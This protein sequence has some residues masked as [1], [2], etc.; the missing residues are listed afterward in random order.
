MLNIYCSGEECTIRPEG[1]KRGNRSA[2]FCL[3]GTELDAFDEN[4]VLRLVGWNREEFGKGTRE[5]STV[6]QTISVPW[7]TGID[8]SSERMRYKISFSSHGEHR[9]W[10]EARGRYDRCSCLLL[11]GLRLMSACYT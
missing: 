8:S 2:Q 11:R 7:W 5:L 9:S 6:I 4:H 10:Q 1:R 3:L